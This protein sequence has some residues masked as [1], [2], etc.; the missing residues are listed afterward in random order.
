[1]KAISK[2]TLLLS[3]ILLSVAGGY[4]Q[5]CMGGDTD[6]GVKVRG[7]IQPQFNYYMN[8]DDAAGNSLN[9]NSFLFNRARLGIL[10]SII[11]DIDYYV[12]AEISPFKTQ[13]ATPYLLDAYVSYTRFA[14]YAKISMGQ[15]KSPF[16]LEQNTSC[17][18]LYTV[19]RSDVVTQLAGPMRD[20]GVMI[21]G[22][23]D[24]TLL[25]Y[26]VGY[27]NG[28]GIGI[29]D[30]NCSKDYV[31]RLV[32][33]PLPYLNV[34]GSFR[35]GKVNP[36]DPTEK[37]NDIYR[38]AAELK[39]EHEGIMLQG[40]YV[41]GLDRLYSASMVPVY[42]GCGGIVG[43]DTKQAGDY[44]KGGYY[45]MASYKTKWNLEPVV[46]YDSYNSDTDTTNQ[47]SDYLTVGLNYYI[48][49]YSRLQI[50]YVFVNEPTSVVN[51][52]F[53]I[54]LQAKF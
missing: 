41:M 34:G 39:F 13:A 11:Y 50:N 12:F 27:M 25:R 45:A 21:S 26:S 14:K 36:T 42:G 49:D 32:F 7:F 48:N 40:E 46:K 3:I 20:L 29:F 37:E 35:A 22:G 31:G 51:N 16:G 43:Y 15:F 17:S 52:M 9:E 47:W 23:N 28:T 4:S 6:A 5:G 18:A 8:G 33:A 54:Q 24:T 19:N 38:Y 10:G 53:I 30:D 44:H 1:M 2:F